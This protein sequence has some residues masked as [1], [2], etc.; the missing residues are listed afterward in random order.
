MRFDVYNDIHQKDSILNVLM[1]GAKMDELDFVAFNGDMVS[2][3]AWKEKIRDTYLKTGAENLQGKVALYNLRGNHEFRGIDTKHWFDY[4]DLPEGKPY[5]TASYG[6]FFFIFLDTA[7]DKPDNDIEYS[8]RAH[9]PR[10]GQLARQRQRQQI[11]HPHPQQ[12]GY[13]SLDCGSQAHLACRRA[14]KGV[15]RRIPRGD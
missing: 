13:Q 5:W 9:L 1:K 10:K 6:K 8:G 15:G 4:A 3:L 2:S 7:E 11:L 12:G 14:W